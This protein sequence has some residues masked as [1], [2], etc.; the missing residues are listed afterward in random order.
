VNLKKA[1]VYPLYYSNEDLPRAIAKP[2][3]MK[4]LMSEASCFFIIGKEQINYRYDNKFYPKKHE[5]RAVGLS[6]PRA[7][8]PTT[9]KFFPPFQI[10]PQGVVELA[11]HFK[12]WTIRAIVGTL[13]NKL[14]YFE[15][16]TEKEFGKTIRMIET[17]EAVSSAQL[18]RVV[19]KSGRRF[20][21][22][23]SFYV[24]GSTLQILSKDNNFDPYSNQNALLEMVT[25]D[26]EVAVLKW[27]DKNHLLHGCALSSKPTGAPA[28]PNPQGTYQ[29]V[30][31]GKDFSPVSSTVD[32]CVIKT[33]TGE[34]Y[35]PRGFETEWECCQR[36]PWFLGCLTGPHILH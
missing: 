18:N 27:F 28:Y 23:T 2:V 36:D 24:N 33:H 21:L 20:E 1:E 26:K 35:G 8:E 17:T 6:F 19:L 14:F 4:R 10:T 16:T 25:F 12:I 29:C 7:M 15:S 9:V 11:S 30:R 5:W 31:C 22:K 34:L 3:H 32:D 13:P